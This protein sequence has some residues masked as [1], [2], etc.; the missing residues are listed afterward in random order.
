MIRKTFIFAIALVIASLALYA[1]DAAKTSVKV[2]GHLI[3]NMC[4]S[5][6][7]GN[8]KAKTHSTACALMP[9]CAKSG[10]TVVAADKSYKLDEE[11]NKM[12]A[13]LLNSTKTKRG[14]S[15]EVQGTLEGDTLHVEHLTEV[16]AAKKTT[17]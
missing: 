7:H 13:S 17:E 10:Y 16:S 1:Q 11:G 3:D 9:G 12:A 2:T 6:E 14:L 8:E 5:G 4:A 15:V